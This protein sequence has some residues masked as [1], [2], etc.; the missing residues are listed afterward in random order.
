MAYTP[1]KPNSSAAL[2][3]FLRGQQ[4][5]STNRRTI[6][7]RRCSSFHSC[8]AI[9]ERPVIAPLFCD[10]LTSGLNAVDSDYEILIC[11]YQGNTRVFANYCWHWLRKVT[12][13][14]PMASVHRD[15]LVIPV[16][17]KAR[18]TVAMPLTYPNFHQNPSIVSW[19]RRG[20][21]WILVALNSS[22]VNCALRLIYSTTP[23]WAGEKIIRR[24]IIHL[25]TTGIR[26]VYPFW[27][28]SFKLLH[29]WLEFGYYKFINYKL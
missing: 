15:W 6:A 16:V 12:P 21:V 28:F 9:C 14:K 20:W 5:N 17:I 26:L 3:V 25:L 10:V 18:P 11:D 13:A 22:F 1:N 4:L 19:W 24:R 8:S 23:P 2:C 29:R 7:A 27:W